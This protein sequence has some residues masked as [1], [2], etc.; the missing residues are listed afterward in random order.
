MVCK[1]PASFPNLCKFYHR[2]G[3]FASNVSELWPRS[4]EDKETVEHYAEI[5]EELP[6]IAIQKGTGKLIDKRVDTLEPVR[7]IPLTPLPTPVGP[8]P[9]PEGSIPIIDAHSQVDEYVELEKI[10]QLMD[11]GGIACTILSTRGKLTLEE[12]ISFAANHPT[13]IILRSGLKAICKR[14]TFGI[15]SVSRSR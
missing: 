6:P 3:V 14:K 4:R 7:F 1:N 2:Q 13:R 9:I 12:L 8:A 11:E 10:I 5:F 15:T